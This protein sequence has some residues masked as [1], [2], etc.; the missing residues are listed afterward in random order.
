[1]TERPLF[2][3]LAARGQ[4]PEWIKLLPLGKLELRD[5]RQGLEVAPEDLD[6]IIRKFRADGV[7]LVVDYEHQSLSGVKAPA[8]GW[9]KDLA[10]RSDGL[11]ARVDWT[12]PARQHIEGEEYR[13]YSPAVLHDPTRHPHT[14]KSVGLVNDPA[15]KGLAPLLAAKF[16]VEEEPEIIALAADDAAKAAQAARAKEYGISVKEGG[17][18][19]KPGEFAEVPDEEWADPVN[20]RYPMGDA[21]HC[22]NALS[23][24]GDE[25]NRAQYTEAERN[26]MGNRMKR[27][28]KA[29]DIQISDDSG[30]MAMKTGVLQLLSL[31]AETPDAEVLA[32]LKSQMALA[33]A[34]PEIIQAVGLDKDAAPALVVGRINAFKATA[35]GAEAAR[36]ELLALKAEQAKE[37]AEG[38]IKEALRTGRTSPEELDRNGGALRTLALKDEGLFKTLV[39]GRP[40]GSV[41]P[42]DQIPRQ[43]EGKKGADGLTPEETLVCKSL[44]ITAEAFKAE[45]KRQAE[46]AG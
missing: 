11:Y 38:M 18:V 5:G 27:R 28:A 30:R 8:A 4:A 1:M 34:M 12:L 41:V 32:V 9:I 29:L 22:Q 15:I 20:Y 40:A 42:I 26:I 35:D 43:P 37:R 3:V 39:M 36:T 19:A 6:A 16:G 23:R 17:H 10:A 44:G 31:R 2:L 25:S 14:L 46:Q 33:A 7:D 24:W 45:Q 21:A 13:Y